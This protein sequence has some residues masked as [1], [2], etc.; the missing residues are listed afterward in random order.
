VIK[1]Q[2]KALAASG[3]DDDHDVEHTTG[4]AGWSSKPAILA[5]F[6]LANFCYE[7]FF[8]LDFENH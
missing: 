6:K 1:D 2:I 4:R 8:R 3:G 7:F 5:A